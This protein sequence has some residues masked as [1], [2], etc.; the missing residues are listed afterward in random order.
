MYKR[1]GISCAA[2]MLLALVL[3][4]S[5]FAQGTSCADIVFGQAITSQFPNVQ[6]ACLDVIQREGKPYAHFQ[7]RVV[8]VRGNEMRVEFKRPDGTYGR[9]VAFDAPA[10]ARARIAGRDYRY[11]DLS[12]GQE[13][14]V[15][16]PADRW[17]IVVQEDPTANF[18]APATVIAAAPIREP[19]PV[20]AAA[21]LPTT[22]SWLPLLGLL[23]L[24]S[25][26]LGAIMVVLRIRQNVSSA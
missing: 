5:S 24:V 21:S 1:T 9:T 22:A 26:A 20:V 10:S 6:S 7:A 8:G 17:E 12:R 4:Q 3:S 2:T 14:D 25:L 13:V 16:L 11:T 15:Y 19:T 18:A 23:G